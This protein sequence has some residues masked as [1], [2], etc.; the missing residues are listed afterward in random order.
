[1]HQLVIE[2][3]EDGKTKKMTKVDPVSSKVT[4]ISF[5]AVILTRHF[6]HVQW[7]QIYVLAVWKFMGVKRIQMKIGWDVQCAFNGSMN[8]VSVHRLHTNK[9]VGRILATFFKPCNFMEMYLQVYQVFCQD[10][11]SRSC[12]ETIEPTLKD[13]VW[14]SI[15]ETL[16]FFVEKICRTDGFFKYLFLSKTD[17]KTNYG[18]KIRVKYCLMNS[19]KVLQK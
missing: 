16:I 14:C 19:L 6:N 10:V 8:C 7:W 2:I 13:L 9:T 5:N 15:T 17:F 3:G 1:M 11:R 18:F 4:K 12:S